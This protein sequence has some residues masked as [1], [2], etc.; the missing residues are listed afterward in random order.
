[1]F[2]KQLA[3][4]AA[5]AAISNAAPAPARHVLHEERQAPPTEWIQGAR[6]ESDAI[7]PMRIGLSQTNLEKGHDFLMEV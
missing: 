7:L 1:M 4:V 2:L 5:I 3:I 6:I